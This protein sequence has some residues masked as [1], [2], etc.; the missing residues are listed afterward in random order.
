MVGSMSI[1]FGW[2]MMRFAICVDASSL[3]FI[4]LSSKSS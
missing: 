1:S 2:S 4:T 3:S